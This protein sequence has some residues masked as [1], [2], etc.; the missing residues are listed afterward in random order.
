MCSVAADVSA[1]CPSSPRKMAPI[2]DHGLTLISLSVTHLA[3]GD[4]QCLVTA[5]INEAAKSNQC[6]R[7][8]GPTDNT[9]TRATV[10]RRVIAR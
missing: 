1:K 8:S 7:P 4:H 9:G 3:G 2:C 6:D 10:D 5:A